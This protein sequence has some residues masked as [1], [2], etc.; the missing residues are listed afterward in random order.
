[1]SNS[2]ST[3]P[4][5]CDDTD[6]IDPAVAEGLTPYQIDRYRQ[7][8]QAYGVLHREAMTIVIPVLPLLLVLICSDN[9]SQLLLSTQRH[10]RDLSPSSSANLVLKINCGIGAL[11]A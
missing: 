6:Q 7:K 9:A 11:D 10:P 3:S 4:L 8:A 2:H 5:G 1:M